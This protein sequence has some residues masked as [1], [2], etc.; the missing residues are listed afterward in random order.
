MYM[1]KE[2]RTHAHTHLTSTHIDTQSRKSNIV[3]I[4]CTSITKMEAPSIQMR[5]TLPWYHWMNLGLTTTEWGLNLSSEIRSSAERPMAGI[6]ARKFKDLLA[7][8]KVVDTEKGSF[9]IRK[10]L[11]EYE[12]PARHMALWNAAERSSMSLAEQI[13]TEGDCHPCL[14]TGGEGNDI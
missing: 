11:A 5:I 12:Q 4:K 7:G 2:A 8:N 13:K 1:C 6:L 3:L 14:H 10:S 9:D